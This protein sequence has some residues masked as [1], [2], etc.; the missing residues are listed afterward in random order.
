[1]NSGL[2]LNC[3]LLKFYLFLLSFAFPTNCV[4]NYQVRRIDESSYLVTSLPDY[5]YISKLLENKTDPVVPMN[6][7]KRAFTTNTAAVTVGDA[8]KSK[9]VPFS[10]IN[11]ARDNYFKN[12]Y[13][14]MKQPISNALL[15]DK[16][17]PKVEFTNNNIDV[18]GVTNKI[19]S[20]IQMARKLASVLITEV[21]Y[22]VSRNW[23][24]SK[25]VDF[26][27]IRNKRSLFRNKRLR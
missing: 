2:V 13:A 8:R 22:Q 11:K 17:T 5:D 26:R 24:N 18:K 23:N 12:F 19:D 15:R 7:D 6:D 4:K 21:Q 27:N 3:I 10:V 25:Q 16:V 9:K 1:M 20:N 14:T